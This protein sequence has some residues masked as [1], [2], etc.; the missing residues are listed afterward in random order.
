[1]A[2][3]GPL[4]DPILAEIFP[5][6]QCSTQTPLKTMKKGGYRSFYGQKVVIKRVSMGQNETFSA[7][8]HP[9]LTTGARDIPNLGVRG[10]GK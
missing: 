10:Q 8:N 2:L 3:F 6:L 5:N 9:N 7:T 1:M 4:F